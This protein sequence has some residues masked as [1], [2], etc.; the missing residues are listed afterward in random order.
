VKA[1]MKQAGHISMGS[2]PRRPHQ[3]RPPRFRSPFLLRAVDGSDPRRLTG[4]TGPTF[5]K[6]MLVC[7]Q[8]DLHD[9]SLNCRELAPGRTGLVHP[10][11]VRLIPHLYVLYLRAWFHNPNLAGCRLFGN[12]RT[13]IHPDRLDFPSNI[14]VVPVWLSA[15]NNHFCCH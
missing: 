12:H 7:K 11:E 3:R 6:Q 13:H 9:L 15:Q 4:A 8:I 14:N 5:T 1:R 2:A 10:L